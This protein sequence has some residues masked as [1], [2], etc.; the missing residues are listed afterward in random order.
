ML[1]GATV[2][3]L[4]TFS[5]FPRERATNS[6]KLINQREANPCKKGDAL[7]KRLELEGHGF[8]YWVRPSIFLTSYV[9]EYLRGHLL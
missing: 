4:A 2:V 8:E 3:V 1:L 9:N 5:R 7:A 6:G